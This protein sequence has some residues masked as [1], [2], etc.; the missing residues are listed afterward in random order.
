LITQDDIEAFAEKNE[1]PMSAALEFARRA[2]KGLPSDRWADGA[3][4]DQ[5]V[6]QGIA[7][8][9]EQNQMLASAFMQLWNEKVK[10]GVDAMRLH[11][12]DSKYNGLQ[13][14]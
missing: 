4:G 12:K 11:G 7:A 1:R 13:C 10:E 5:D 9:F 14:E 6:A 2:Q 3:S 8:L